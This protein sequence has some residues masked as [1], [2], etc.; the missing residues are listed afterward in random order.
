MT[1]AGIFIA[2]WIAGFAAGYAA[3]SY[4]S[5]RRRT[6]ER[7]ARRSVAGAPPAFTP[8]G[9]AGIREP[10][11]VPWMRTSPPSMVD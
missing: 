10:E 3:R 1:M 6:R 9:E 7:L 4:I 5:Y 2:L 11:R 8:L